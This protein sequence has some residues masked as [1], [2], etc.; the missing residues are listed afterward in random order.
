MSDALLT[1]LAKAAG[2]NIDWIDAFDN[3]QTVTPQT[4]RAILEQ[5][6]FAAQTEEQ[7]QTSLRQLEQDN[8]GTSAPLITHDQNKPLC[9]SPRFK[10][11]SA[12]RLTLE[13]GETQNGH[14]DESATLGPVVDCGYHLLTIDNE[15][16]TLAVAPLA[17]PSVDDLTGEQN[18]RIWGLTAQLY[19]LRRP[20][21]GGLGDTGALELLVHQAAEHGADAVAISPVHAMF[22]ADTSNYSPYSPS[23]RMFFNILHSAPGQILGDQALADAVSQSGLQAEMKRLEELDLVDWPAASAV[24]IKLLRQ[25]HESFIGQGGP[26]HEDFVAFTAAGGTALAQHCRFEAL[27]AFMLS[28]GQPGDWRQWPQEF[29]DPESPAVERFATEHQSEV[30]FHCFAQWLITRSLQRAQ[31]AACDAGMRVGL[32]ADLAVGAHGSGS[33][34]WTRQS[35]F[36]PAISVGAPPDILNGN[37]QNWGIS[38]FSPSGLKA[39]GFRAFIEML[40]ANLAYAGGI[41]I[42]HVMGLKRL[43]VMPQGASP[44]DGAYLDYPFEDQLRLLALEAWRHKALVVGEDLGTVPSG[45]RE[46]LARRNILGMRVLLFEQDKGVFIPSADWPQDALATTTTHDL[47]SITGWYEGRDID[48]RLEAGHRS[49]EQTEDDR[50]LREE[51]KAALT[52]AL[53]KD[54]RLYGNQPGPAERLMASIEF[55]GSTPAPLVLLPLEDA[56]GSVEQPNLPGPGADHPNWRRRWTADAAIMLSEPSVEDRLERLASARKSKRDT[57]ND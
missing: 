34:T 38:A 4:Q 32:I 44:Q 56:L 45:M 8:S 23:S 14:L 28:D 47:P 46:E 48:W 11:G 29:R 31:K 24:R 49:A 21:D 55:V 43:W 16:V 37:G 19:S 53:R 57:L 35:E 54:G 36:L 18:A 13:S 20:G 7:I 26:Q 22:T 10:P 41:R 27:H 15:H 33:Q 39:N 40:R 12:Y 3:P 42:D 25:L 1:R 51:E 17:C 50:P 5:L 9:L 2:I 30:D 52:A 6:G